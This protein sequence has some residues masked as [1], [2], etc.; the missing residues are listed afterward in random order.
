MPGDS[1]RLTTAQTIIGVQV[2]RIKKSM[3]RGTLSP[4]G[5]QTEFLLDVDKVVRPCTSEK[6]VSWLGDALVVGILMA[7]SV[8]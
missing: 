3:R 7:S 8:R 4:L 5:D 1:R 2:R 6:V